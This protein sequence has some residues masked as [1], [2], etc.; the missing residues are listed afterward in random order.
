V[1][2]SSCA[3][4]GIGGGGTGMDDRGTIVLV[5]KAG[6]LGGG[7]AGRREGGGGG[8][9]RRPPTGGGGGLRDAGGAGTVLDFIDGELF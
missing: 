4:L 5:G 8:G 7:G 6:R 1:G 2:L 3:F 9:G